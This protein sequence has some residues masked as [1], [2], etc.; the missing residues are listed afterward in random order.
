MCYLHD[1]KIRV[2]YLNK[3]LRIPMGQ[4]K[5]DNPKKLATWVIRIRKSND[6]QHNDQ[7]K[8][9]KRTSNDLQNTTQKTKYRTTRTPSKYGLIMAYRCSSVHPRLVR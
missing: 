2:T 6:R 1:K 3:R 4:L 8:K 9:G 5:I 7:M